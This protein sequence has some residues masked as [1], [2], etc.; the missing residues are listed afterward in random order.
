VTIYDTA[1]VTHVPTEVALAQV[2]G[3]CDARIVEGLRAEVETIESPMMVAIGD[4]EIG[5]R[6]HSPLHRQDGTVVVPARVELTD[7]LLHRI[8]IEAHAL[9]LYAEVATRIGAACEVSIVDDQ[10]DS[11]AVV[12]SSGSEDDDAVLAFVDGV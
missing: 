11:D 2:A 8:E 12:V 10:P 7:F 5:M 9:E 4:L 3:A 6:L 1:L